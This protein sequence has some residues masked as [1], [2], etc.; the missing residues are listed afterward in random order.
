MPSDQPT[1]KPTGPTQAPTR[2]KPR[3]SAA[4]TTTPTE[5]QGSRGGGGGETKGDDSSLIIGA[6]AAVG[7]A[8]ASIVMVAVVYRKNRSKKNQH[9]SYESDVPPQSRTDDNGDL[10]KTDAASQYVASE[11]T[12]IE[13]EL[14]GIRQ[15]VLSMVTE[16]SP[17]QEGAVRD[18]V[19]RHK[20]KPTM[21]QK[22][23]LVSF[24]KETDPNRNDIEGAVEKLAGTYTF[25][26]LKRAIKVR[27]GKLP[28]GWRTGSDRSW[29]SG[30][31]SGKHVSDRDHNG[32]H[33]P[34]PPPHLPDSI[35]SFLWMHTF[36]QV[37]Y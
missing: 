21:S 12:Q 15:G 22:L 30:R 18:S 32:N 11:V 20:R 27:Y 28:K 36:V 19:A 10:M 3:P 6:A 26:N 33:K 23:A 4:P 31:F 14:L 7:A 13:R 16:A 9:I 37:N 34:L 17:E 8:A 5:T 35:D 2:T 25:A 29:G 24:M 1:A